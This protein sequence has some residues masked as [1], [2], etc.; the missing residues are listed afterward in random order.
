MQKAHKGSGIEFP[1]RFGR[2][3]MKVP[4][5][6]LVGYDWKGRWVRVHR[7]GDTISKAGWRV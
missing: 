3:G 6:L 5:G 2:G 1:L 4:C 7:S